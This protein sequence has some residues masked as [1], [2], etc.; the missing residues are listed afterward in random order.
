MKMEYPEKTTEL[1]QIADKL[2]HIM[3]Y[4]VHLLLTRNR[5]FIYLNNGKYQLLMLSEHEPSDVTIKMCQLEIATYL[6]RRLSLVRSRG[7]C[8]NFARYPFS[9]NETFPWDWLVGLRW[10]SPDTPISFTNNTDR[11]EIT[12]ILNIVESGVK[13]HNPNPTSNQTPNSFLLI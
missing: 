8:F 1:L 13:H 9:V 11:H 12:E 10:F 3:L 7:S 2:Y 6:D 5:T 4:P